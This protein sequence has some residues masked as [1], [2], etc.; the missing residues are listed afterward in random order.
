MIWASMSLMKVNDR[1]LMFNKLNL[2]MLL[3]SSLPLS[4]AQDKCVLNLI[5]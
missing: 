1:N 5:N 3:V 2:I 4:K